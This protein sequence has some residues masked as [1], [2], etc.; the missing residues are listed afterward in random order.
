M[1][2]TAFSD[3]EM[4]V[5]DDVV[6]FFS[7]ELSPLKPPDDIKIIKLRPTTINVTWTPLSLFEAQGFPVYRVTLVYTGS[8]S[9]RQSN[10]STLI[11]QN[12]SAL[13]TDLKSNQ[14][15]SLTVGVATNA[16]GIYTSSEPITGMQPF[17]LFIYIA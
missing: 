11:T 17:T 16:L 2:V 1:Q 4:G 3:G 8:R 5:Q 14:E 7:K 13:F 10:S 15:Y 9:K 6:E 12:N